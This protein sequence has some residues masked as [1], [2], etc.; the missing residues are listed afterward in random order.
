[1]YTDQCN[2]K[3]TIGLARFSLGTWRIGGNRRGAEKRDDAPHVTKEKVRF[4]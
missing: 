4:I 1:M 3:E 2:Q